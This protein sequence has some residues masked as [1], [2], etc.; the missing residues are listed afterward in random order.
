MNSCFFMLQL[1]CRKPKRPLRWTTSG[2]RNARRASLASRPSRRTCRRRTTPTQDLRP[3]RPA[4]ARRSASTRRPPPGAHSPVS[5]ATWPSRC[6][7]T[8]RS[9]NW[10][11][12]PTHKSWVLA[13]LLCFVGVDIGSGYYFGFSGEECFSCIWFFWLILI[14]VLIFRHFFSLKFKNLY[15]RPR[16]SYIF[17]ST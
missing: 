14:V 2:A 12:H 8:S 10:C 4:S 7:N 9:T 17:L 6:A 13:H 3:R 11:T 5:S 15:R 1:I 16:T